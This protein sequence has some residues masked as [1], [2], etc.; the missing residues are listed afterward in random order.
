ME[1]ITASLHTHDLKKSFMQ[2][3]KD[4]NVLSGITVNFSQGKT[5]AITGVS[6]SGKSTFMHLLAGLDTPSAGA[7]T[8]NNTDISK[9]NPDA[10]MKFLNKEIGLVFQ[11]PYLIR[12]LSVLENCMIKGL[13]A[14]N[15]FQDEIQRAIELLEKVGLADKAYCKPGA[16]SGGQQQRVAIV[17]AIFNRPTFL[18][19]DEP[20]GSLDEGM[21]TEIV[22]LLLQ[23]QKEWNMG[24]VVSSHDPIVYKR[25]EIVY[26]LHNGL[27]EKKTCY[28]HNILNVH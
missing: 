18:L 11:D 9:L 21:G 25:M 8:Y 6:G 20:T 3:K 2:G 23:C 12:E 19:A 5:Y 1:N 15:S 7:I 24:L 28:R 17:R 22:N 10:R 14:G 27:L 16:L 13:I 26:H 4:L